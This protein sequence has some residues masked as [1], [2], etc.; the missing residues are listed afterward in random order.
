MAH[1][2]CL[3]I[4]SWDLFKIKIPQ[5]NDYT[6]PCGDDYPL[7]W[8]K[9]RE[10][11]LPVLRVVE[12]ALWHLTI[13]HTFRA[14]TEYKLGFML[15]IALMVLIDTIYTLLECSAPLDLSV[16][17]F[18]LSSNLYSAF[19]NFSCPLPTGHGEAVCLSCY[20]CLVYIQWGGVVFSFLNKF[21]Y[22]FI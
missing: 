9:V 10:T 16:A 20:S 17:V 21:I 19:S 18:L 12:T 3:G 6:L 15:R 14:P 8:M 11:T 5:E 4:A 1:L 22:L 13:I 7:A 2:V